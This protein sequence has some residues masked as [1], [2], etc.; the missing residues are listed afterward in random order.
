MAWH[1]L[2]D[3]DLLAQC[4]V[5]AFRGSGPGGQHRN[6]TETAVRLVHLPSGVTATGA[7]Q[8]SREQNLRAA[9]GRLREK[10]RRLAHRPPPRRP[11]NPTRASKE[12]RVSDKKKRARLKAFRRGSFE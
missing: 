6:K 11:T 7:D 2:A 5:H 8:R 3:E 10:L 1:A 12:R 9:L 4:E